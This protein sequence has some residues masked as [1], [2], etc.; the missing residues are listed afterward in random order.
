MVEFSNKYGPI[1]FDN[2]CF[3]KYMIKDESQMKRNIHMKDMYF[4]DPTQRTPTAYFKNEQMFYTNTSS[5]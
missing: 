3:S 1:I 4:T 5:E 2:S